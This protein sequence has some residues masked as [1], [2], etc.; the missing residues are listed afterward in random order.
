MS[1]LYPLGF[2]GLIG[3]IILAVIY[4]IKPNYQNKFIS[5]T[6]VWKLSLKYRKKR[7][8]ISK[9]RNIILII[10][11]VLAIT[12][13]S[14]LL[15]QP[16]IDGDDANAG[17]EKVIIIDASANMLAEVEGVTRF[18]RAVDGA[19]ALAKETLDNG[20]AV[21]VILASRK[22]S[23]LV[24]RLDSEGEEA[25]MQALG[26]LSNTDCCY[27]AGDIDGAMSLAETVI[28]ENPKA[29]IVFYTGT[30]YID[31][32]KVTVKSVADPSEWNVAIL[33]VRAVLDENY[34]RFEVDAASYARSSGVSVYLDI[35][36][37]KGTY[38]TG[39]S[40][41]VFNNET[42]SVS[43]SALLEM[44]ETQTVRF[45]NGE[46]NDVK[47]LKITAYDTVYCHVEA[48]D[49]I[50]TDN[51]FYL[52][53]GTAQQLNI[54]YYSTLSNSFV[55]GIL[56]GL[57]NGL[58]DDWDI[59]ITELHD[60]KE[61]VEAGKGLEPA[62]EGFDVY[63]F[64]H[65]MPKALPTDG[66][67]ILIDPDALPK[68]SDFVVSSNTVGYNN[69]L[70]LSAGDPH[71]V[72]SFVDAE[73][74]TLT[75]F[76]KITS[77]DSCYTPLLYADDS[78]VAIMKYEAD[79]K[80]VVFSFSLHYSNIALTPDFPIL[81][82]NLI[83][84]YIPVTFENDSYEVY[85]SVSLNSR[86]PSLKVDLPSGERLEF[87]EFPAQINVDV[88]GSYTTTQTPI[89]GVD[90]IETFF[91]TMPDE[92]SN[93]ALVE[94]SLTQPYYPPEEESADID[95]VFWFALA[96]VALLFCEWWLKSRE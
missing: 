40:A 30:T 24:Q 21:S 1:W 84:H 76:K 93:I 66:L 56:M 86:S 91:V 10:C 85:D 38:G 95:L 73:N 82:Y 27:S 43:F 3:L 37:A 39:E 58:K 8:P 81:M 41:E 12:A 53:G 67:V 77:Y 69:E 83:D 13:C 52:Y 11:Q 5:S 32:G 2:L 87:T 96:L 72:M 64:E 79:S 74:I 71:E 78:P 6:F 29:E 15:A 59:E 14:F 4:L 57:R 75:R 49:S 62:L 54:Q 47:D 51:Y 34:Y 7:L 61:A 89:S 68:G 94:D 55:S 44:N 45:G 20:G 23:V 70:P 48:I 42:L 92:Q 33:D 46:E 35:R 80:L 26:G 18:D 90:T 17:K 25:A 19:E 50:D 22:A 88:P 60:S 31:D 36:G 65:H 63:I 9:L 28:A 16:F